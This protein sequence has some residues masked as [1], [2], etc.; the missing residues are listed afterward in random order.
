MHT[1]NLTD[2]QRSDLIAILIIYMASLEDSPEE[3]RS[4]ND[5]LLSDAAALMELFNKQ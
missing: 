1:Y 2:K 5:D 3:D 4:I